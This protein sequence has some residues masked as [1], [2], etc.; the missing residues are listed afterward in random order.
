MTVGT[1]S[2][3]DF[4]NWLLNQA[5]YLLAM[6]D[7]PRVLVVAEAT[8]EHRIARPLTERLCSSYT[9]KGNT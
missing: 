2:L 9:C 6:E 7:P 1:D 8:V 3:F 5:D 4:I